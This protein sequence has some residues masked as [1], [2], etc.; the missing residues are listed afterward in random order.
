[1]H[2]G[3]YGN[4]DTAPGGK[5]GAKPGGTDIGLTCPRYL[6]GTENHLCFGDLDD[7]IVVLKLDYQAEETVP[8]RMK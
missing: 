2:L 1:M 3:R 7:R 4:F 8:T 6:G 5:A